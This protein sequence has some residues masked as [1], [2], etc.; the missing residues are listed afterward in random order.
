M[1]SSLKVAV[2]TLL[3]LSAVACGEKR[4]SDDEKANAVRFLATMPLAPDPDLDDVVFDGCRNQALRPGC[5]G[6]DA[7]MGVDPDDLGISGAFGAGYCDQVEAWIADWPEVDFDVDRVMVDDR[8]C[9]FPG[10]SN[11][12]SV[13]VSAIRNSG[14]PIISVRLYVE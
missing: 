7:R 6:L 3:V 11:D 2:L 10:S 12:F 13:S 1:R 14:S 4:W 8:S 9:Y 5:G